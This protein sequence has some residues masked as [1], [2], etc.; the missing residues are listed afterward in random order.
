MKVP[1]HKILLTLFL[2]LFATAFAAVG[3]CDTTA[4]YA[5][6]YLGDDFISDGQSYRALLYDDQVA[7]FHTTL[8]GGSKYRIVSFSGREKGQLI[9][10]LYDQEDNLLFSNEGHENSPHWDFEVEESLDCRLEARLDQVK[11]SSGC[12]V[13]L[14]GFER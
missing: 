11:Q 9:F 14:I 10:S 8:F 2:G 13:L 1:T 5:R 3:Q 12:V 4:Q 6:T 7:E